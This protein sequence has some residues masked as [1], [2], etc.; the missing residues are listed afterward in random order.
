MTAFRRRDG[1]PHCHPQGH[2]HSGMGAAIVARH[3]LSDDDRDGI[4]DRSHPQK[5]NSTPYSSSCRLWTGG[6]RL[7]TSGSMSSSWWTTREPATS[8]SRL[9]SRISS[10][11]TTTQR[12]R[13]HRPS[14]WRCSSS[15]ALPSLSS[16]SPRRSAGT[17]PSPSPAPPSSASAGSAPSSTTPDTTPPDTA[18]SRTATKE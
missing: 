12:R 8:C 16:V 3:R 14:T 9:T 13:R 7:S 1:L 5:F 6:W 11:T 18:P 4:T 17:S 2:V 10:R 15:P